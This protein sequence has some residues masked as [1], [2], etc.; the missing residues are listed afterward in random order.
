M[1]KKKTVLQAF[2]GVKGVALLTAAF[3]AVIGYKTWELDSSQSALEAVGVE[4]GLEYSQNSRRP[5]LRGRIDDIGVEITVTTDRTFGRTDQVNYQTRFRLY[6]EGGPYGK[7]VG[8]SLRESIVKE[9]SDKE[10][11]TTGDPAFDNAVFVIGNPTD[12]LAHLNPDARVA[13]I[14]ATAAGWVLDGFTWETSELGRMT[15]PESVRRVLKIGLKAARVTR[16][17]DND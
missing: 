11:I 14:E 9:F 17:A 2:G 13:V 15:S 7:I 8:A 1:N 5:Q 6:P 3:L 10:P 16:L 4:L 12:L